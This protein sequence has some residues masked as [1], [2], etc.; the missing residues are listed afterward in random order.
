MDIKS[1]VILILTKYRPHMHSWLAALPR[2]HLKNKNGGLR[3][4]ELLVS[5][6]KKMDFDDTPCNFDYIYFIEFSIYLHENLI[7]LNSSNL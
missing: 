6:G 7:S 1:C 5:D 4:G 2:R 3:K